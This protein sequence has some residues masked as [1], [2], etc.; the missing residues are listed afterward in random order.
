MLAGAAISVAAGPVPSDGGASPPENVTRPSIRSSSRVASP[1]SLSR[2]ATNV[3]APPSAAS[4]RS[5]SPYPLIALIGVRRSWRSVRR[6]LRQVRAAI[7]PVNGRGIEQAEYEAM[8]IPAGIEDAL[9]IV[10]ELPAVGLHRVVHQHLGI[11]HDGRRRR[12]QFLPHV[13]NERPLRSP[14]GSLVNLIGRGTTPVQRAA[15]SLSAQAALGTSKA[16]IL[17]SRRDISTGL[18]S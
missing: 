12:A 8:E 3:S 1:R 6:I 10:G 4:S 5:I 9:K 11:A 2:S 16:A 17:P 18:V 14:V 13:G 7:G 15:P